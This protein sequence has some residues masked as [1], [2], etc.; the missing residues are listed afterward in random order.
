VADESSHTIRK[1][2]PAGVVATFAGLAGNSG[3]ADGTGSAARFYSPN[4]VAEDSAGNVFVADLYNHTIRKVT[5]AGTV[6]TLAGLAGSTGSTDGAG[7]AARFCCPSGVAADSA[8][9]VFVADLY[10]FTIR[11]VT[12]AGV[13]TTIGGAP[14]VAGGVDGVGSYANFSYPTDV[15]V[16]T[17]GNLYVADSNNNRIS[18][19]TPHLTGDI[20][21]DSYVNIGDLQL[22]V[23][24]WGSGPAYTGPEDISG[25]SYVNVGDLQLLVANW[26]RHL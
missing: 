1:I 19:G 12:A 24:K 18:K 4:S 17:T 2:T 21:C 11:K 10:N 13:V 5:A 9:N 14:G 6:T 22:L 8:G 3:S 16:D 26:G 25:D 7:S 20:N 15:A 23:A